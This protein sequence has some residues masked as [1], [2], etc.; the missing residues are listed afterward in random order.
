MSRK[1]GMVI[2]GSLLLGACGG[3]PVPAPREA[4]Q[5]ES[6]A[7]AQVA[8]LDETTRNGVFEQAIRASGAPCPTVTASSRAEPR[9]GVRGWKAQ[10]D[11]GSAHLIEITE[12][13][14]AKVTSRTD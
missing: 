9:P 4:A 3:D 12:D 1:S 11:N 2:A 8:R 13:G 5:V 10:C 14:T 6:G 7:A